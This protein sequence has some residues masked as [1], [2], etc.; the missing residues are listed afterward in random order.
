ML[1]MTKISPSYLCSWMY[2]TDASGSFPK[3][4][5]AWMNGEHREELVSTRLGRPTGLT[6]DDHMNDRVF[7][8]DSK[9][10]LIE[11]MNADGSDRI[12]VIGKGVLSIFLELLDLTLV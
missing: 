2:W 3:I 12:I 4:E 9:E 7:W 6:I 10:N 11:S 1:Q 5:R 8:C